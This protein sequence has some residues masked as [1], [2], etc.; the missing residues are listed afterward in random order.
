MTVE[1][2]SE[3]YDRRD[4]LRK[5]LAD[6]KDAQPTPVIHKR[7]CAALGLE[8]HILKTTQRDLE[9]LERI[10]EVRQVRQDSDQRANFWVW[11]GPALDLTLLPTEAVTLSAMLDHAA[12]LGMQAPAQVLQKLRAHVDKVMSRVPFRKFDWAKRITTGTR[13]TVLKAGQFDPAHVDSIHDALFFNQPLKVTYLPRDAGGVECVYHLKPLALSYQDSNIYLSAYVLEEEWPEGC[14]P[15]PGARRGKYSS[16]GPGTFCAL[17]LHR[18]V[19][20]ED[21]SLYIPDPEDFDVNSLEAQRHL[22]TIHADEPVELRLRLGANLHNRL[23]ENPLADQQVLTPLADGKWELRCSILDTQGLRLFLLANADEIEVLAP[24][25]IRAHV[26]DAVRQ[27]ASFYA[28]DP[29]P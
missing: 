12:R 6:Y 13:F 1:N 28:E 27:A 23:S 5:I 24:P 9:A 25:V 17:M 7:L 16:N 21:S 14:E 15:Q 8:N 4:C 22:M 18:V 11:L 2:K 26:R 3:L 29:T 10:G 20:I 19:A